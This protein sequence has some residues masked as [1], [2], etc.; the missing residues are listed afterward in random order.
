MNRNPIYC[1]SQ[2]Y[3]RSAVFWG[4]IDFR[5]I[6][7]AREKLMVVIATYDAVIFEYLHIQNVYPIFFKWKKNSHIAQ[8]HYKLVISKFPLQYFIMYTQ[9]TCRTPMIVRLKDN[10]RKDNGIFYRKKYAHLSIYLLSI[11]LQLIHIITFNEN[12]QLSRFLNIFIL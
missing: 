5:A 2:C 7:L 9:G 12:G 10:G 8:G 6:S 3:R 11:I 1:P 4:I